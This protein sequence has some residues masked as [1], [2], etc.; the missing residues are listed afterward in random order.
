M[1]RRRS[2]RS[3]IA[4]AI[5]C[6][7]A[8]VGA[9]WQAD[10]AVP[11]SA[12]ALIVYIAGEYRRTPRVGQGLA[13]VAAMAAILVAAF[14]PD[15][16]SVLRRAAAMACLLAAFVTAMNFLREVA[17]TSPLI[18]RCGQHIL[19]QPPRRRYGGLTIAGNLFGI[20]TAFGVINLLGVMIVRANSLASAGGDEAVRLARERRSMLALLRGF[21]HTAQ[22][23]PV[24]VPFAVIASGYPDLAWV[25]I[26]PLGMASAALLIALGWLMDTATGPRG[27]GPAPPAAGTVP[28]WTVH[29]GLAGLIV[30][31]FAILLAVDGL[32]Q[33]SFIVAAILTVPGFAMGWIALQFARLGG[34]RAVALAGRRLR[35]IVL[36]RFAGQRLET[37]V[38]ASAGFLGAVIAAT[39]DAGQITAFVARSE[40]APVVIPLAAIWLVIGLGH[41]GLTP[42]VSTALI[43]AAISDPEA[44]GVPL[45]LF[46]VAVLGAWGLTQQS[47]PF[48][49]PPL[50]VG[51]MVGRSSHVVG[52]RWNGPYFLIGAV[53]HSAWIYVVFTLWPA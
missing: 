46:A 48:N 40:V 22:W 35:R 2:S 18:K 45:V 34:R 52:Q 27:A 43:V 41:I 29:I 32:I 30:T 49:I 39:M 3:G 47:S 15:P 25:D 53:V 23:S 12:A 28:Q 11:V 21:G 6:V 17:Q 8:I 5:A 26:L 1:A 20:L 33:K 31:L 36:V 10:V 13:A 37:T 38:L 4:L 50:L 42:V 24:A 51:R 14:A 7:A 9:F 16:L 44:F 19:A